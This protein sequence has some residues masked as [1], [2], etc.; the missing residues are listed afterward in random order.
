MKCERVGCKKQLG[1]VCLS[2]CLSVLALLIRNFWV[3][4]QAK[5]YNTRRIQIFTTK[6]QQQ[7][8][9]QQ[10][11]E[12]IE[13]N[14]SILP[15]CCCCLLIELLASCSFEVYGMACTYCRSSLL[16]S[17]TTGC[18]TYVWKIRQS[19]KNQNNLGKCRLFPRRD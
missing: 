2:V 15:N 4:W 5:K 11:K 12:V 14:R 18:L 7:Q 17:S 19:R 10:L 3:T 8:Q 1:Q 16:L 9:L 13:L 6:K